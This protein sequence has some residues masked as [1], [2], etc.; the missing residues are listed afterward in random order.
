MFILTEKPSVAQSFADALG[1]F[2]KY[3]GYYS[4]GKDCIV[5]AHGHL[6]ALCSPED[7]DSRFSGKWESSFKALPIIPKDYRY[8]PIADPTKTLSKIK[9]C[10]KEFDS[11]D[12]ILATD[13]ERE[14]ELIGALIL[15]H[16][17]FKHYDTAR[18]FWVSEALTPDVVKKGL[19]AAK[20]LENYSSYKDA[21]YA[22][23]KADW[24]IGMNFTRFITVSTG[25]LCSFG[26]CQTSILSAIYL[27]D[28]NI[29]N[30]VPV[31]YNQLSVKVTK[32]GM[33]FSMLL[34][35]TK[36]QEY[37][38]RFDSTDFFPDTVK[39][40]I[41]PGNSLIV[42]DV[43]KDKKTE[44]PPQL[45]NI[46]GLQKYCSNNFKL[47]PTQTLEI[48]QQLY[49]ELKVLSYPRTP[50]VILG[51]D[52]VDLYREKFNLLSTKYKEY[53]EGCDTD[54]ISNTNK[55]LFNSAK[56]QD[57]HALIPLAPLPDSATEAQ[58]NVY[59]AVLQ[60]FFQVI[61]KEHVYSQIT[62]EAIFKD[63]HF[64][65]KGKAI[66]QQGWKTGIRN[67]NE[68]DETSLPEV[69]K[70]DSLKIIFSE[71]LHKETKPKKHFTNATILALMENPK[72]EDETNVKLAGIGTPAT[73]AAIIQTLID[74][75]YI[76]QE[77]QNLLITEK[78]CFLI[79]TVI[80][81]PSL[82]N[83]ISIKTTTEWEQNLQDNPNDFLKKITDFVATEIPKIKITDKWTG[84]SLG[85]C[86]L[87]NGMIL[88][89]K[90]GYYCSEWKSGCK[91]TVWKE[92]SGAKITPSDIKL[93]LSGKNTS[94]KKFV[95]KSGK[96]F[97]AS[98]R[99]TFKDKQTNLDFVYPK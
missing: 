7:Y 77:K 18:R 16:I 94:S 67:C 51:D 3:D 62:V 20:P 49:E 58:K 33:E 83:F 66:I 95:N 93:L 42:K 21:G 2:K 68:E 64:I 74:R 65:A 52:N 31:P 6:L 30:F 91:F 44:N 82:A 70:G 41:L 54:L 86:P 46:T 63:F 84:D 15:A 61:K 79:E 78:G 60:R 26:R 1:G 38:D 12:F 28:K 8:K 55:R 69:E 81:I 37:P 85:K 11:T 23:S 90:K 39:K 57:H 50:S 98:L 9:N 56:L 32:N 17:G 4:N 24:L 76:K 25:T 27:R 10:F 34:Q 53:A 59:L 87:C 80:K 71:I 72:A 48:A 45:F 88:E 36:P 29:K 89:G 96:S 40:Q 47:T 75:K 99:L 22:R 92:V 73:R 14:G 5:S 35:A 19:A 97:N 43:T 13:A